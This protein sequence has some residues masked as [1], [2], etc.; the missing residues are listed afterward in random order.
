LPFTIVEKA[1]SVINWLAA[2]ATDVTEEMLAMETP[3]QLL[4]G[5]TSSGFT[6]GNG[7]FPDQT[8][9][10]EQ[11]PQPYLHYRTNPT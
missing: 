5:K 4:I 11:S 8:T 3:P 2:E 6:S 1:V 10:P 9:R 7:T